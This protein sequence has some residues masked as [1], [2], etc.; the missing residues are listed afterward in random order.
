MG[1]K[2]YAVQVG[3]DTATDNGSTRKR[4]ALAMAR[5]EAKANPKER[6][7]LCVCTNDDDFCLDEIVVQEGRRLYSGEEVHEFA[8]DTRLTAISD[9]GAE[10]DAIYS[11]E[12]DTIYFA[13]PRNIRIVGYAVA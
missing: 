1:K 4:E 8:E 11:A 2:W 9:T 5:R 6:V 7:K 13:I 3:N 10:Y 12:Y